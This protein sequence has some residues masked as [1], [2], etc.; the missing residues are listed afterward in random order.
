MS[1]SLEDPPSD[2]PSPAPSVPTLPTRTP[3]LVM[4]ETA[5]LASTASLMWFINYY[6]PMGPLL[7]IFFPVPIALLYMRWGSR[8]AWMGT[9]VSG[10]LLSVLMGPTRSIL[11]V[12][13]YGLMSVQLGFLWRRGSGWVS[14]IA[15]GTIIGTFGVFFRL[16]LVSILLGDDL[17]LYLMTQ[18][19][20]MMDWIFVK[21]G[22]LTQPSLWLIQALALF[23]IVLNNLIYLFVVHLVALLLLDRLGTPIPRPPEWIEVLIDYERT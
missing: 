17:W 11:F 7:R 10:L 4:V 12:I 13:P 22:L 3:S 5:F 8:A 18:I 20:E 2:L 15:L 1:N 6:F 23:M 9:L 21:L 16:W 14:A 19:T